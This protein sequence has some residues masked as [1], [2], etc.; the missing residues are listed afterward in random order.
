MAQDLVN[1]QIDRQNILNNK[2]ALE[3]IKQNLELKFVNF[4]GVYYVTRQMVADFYEVDIRTITNCLNANEEEL[5][6]NGYKLL[7]GNEL[8]EFK[9][10]LGKEINFPTKTTVLGVFD[11]RSFL[12]LGMLLTT[13]E[14]A[15]KLRA[16][17]LDVVIAT[18]NGKTG[19]GTTYINW[20]DRDFLPAAIQEEDYHKKFTGVVKAC[21]SGNATGKYGEITNMIYKAVFCEHAD[22]YRA[23]LKLKPSDNVRRTLYTEVLRVISSFENT[24]AQSVRQKNMELERKVSMSEIQRMVN[25]IAQ[26]PMMEPFLYE[27]RQKMA[28][29]DNGF[30]QVTHEELLGYIKALAPDEFDR[31]LGD[32]SVDIEKLLLESDENKDFLQ[33]LN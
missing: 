23:L 12:N 17:M 8:K 14:K 16:M 30:R 1:S 7:Q 22:E 13:S 26:S 20:K 19:G 15:K 10:Q 25:E 21:V 28:S 31:F 3:T 5:K 18:I 6:F 11:F 24:L 29:R 27:A 4:K 2:Y 33:T 9:L 32:K